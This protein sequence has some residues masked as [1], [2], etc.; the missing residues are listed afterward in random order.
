MC[1]LASN[2]CQQ[3]ET[4]SR[5][6]NIVHAVTVLNTIVF[7][8]A[9]MFFKD[10]TSLFDKAW[11]K[12]GFCIS[13]P[14]IP[15]WSSHDLC[16]YADF[17]LASVCGIAYLILRKEDGMQQANELFFLNIFGVAAHGMGHG[18]IGAGMRDEKSQIFI[19]TDL[20]Y[21][22]AI[23]HKPWGAILQHLFRD[24]GFFLVFWLV[25]LKASMPQSPMR[26]ILPLSILS[27]FS[28]LSLR[29]SFSFTFVQ[30]VLLI[31]FSCNQIY[32]PKSEK[33]FAYSIYGLLVSFP[34]GIIGWMES[35]MCSSTIV[36]LGGHLCYDA[37]IPLSSL[38]FY[39][40]CYFCRSS[41]TV[42]VKAEW[43]VWH[44]STASGL[45]QQGRQRTDGTCGLLLQ[46]TKIVKVMAD[47]LRCV[48]AYP[49]KWYNGHCL[50]SGIKN[51][52]RFL[53]VLKATAT[54]KLRSACW[55]FS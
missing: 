46:A 10:N 11:A 12:D 50:I 36:H 22:S 3:H 43:L 31:A 21:L 1:K 32:R 24:Q 33:G 8:I 23:S 6:G 41:E 53:H 45:H 40:T 49:S 19:D 14:D 39:L 7:C 4:Y 2:F 27:W 34:V 47:L 13:N 26:F 20:P 30:T 37:Y 17:I 48:C 28:G 38:A 29:R 18:A 16:L 52:L 9:V 42:K 15:Y 55:V 5:R 44:L 51:W 25:L 35:I 54:V